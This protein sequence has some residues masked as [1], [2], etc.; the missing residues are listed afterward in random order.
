[1]TKYVYYINCDNVDDNNVDD[2][3]D[4][5]DVNILGCHSSRRK[6][7]FT[8]KFVCCWKKTSLTKQSR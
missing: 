7:F 6:L 8:C 3:V 5:D 2:V 1:M 4:V